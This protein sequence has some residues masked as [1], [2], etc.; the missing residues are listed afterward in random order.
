MS[1][2]ST[3][4]ENVCTAFLNALGPS[5]E[6]KHAPVLKM[7]SKAR[8]ET[9]KTKESKHLKRT[10]TKATKVTPKALKNAKK[11]K[12]SLS[13]PDA[14]IYCDLL[15]KNRNEL[16]QLALKLKLT[17]KGDKRK[18]STFV[19]ALQACESDCADCSVVEDWLDEEGECTDYSASTEYCL[20]EYGSS[21]SEQIDYSASTE[22]CLSE[23]GS[24]GSEQIYA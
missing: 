24:S 1:S 11:T 21:G 12:E 16:K 14:A 7:T 18:K 13:L 15:S 22:Y 2:L 23:Y 3:S 5:A 9:K 20:S 8:K 17:V 4:I 6:S 10:A 19:E